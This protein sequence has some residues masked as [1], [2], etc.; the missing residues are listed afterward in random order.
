MTLRY[1]TDIVIFGGGIA[2]L[3]LLNRLQ[4]I[5]YSPLLFETNTLGG[6][7]T[8]AS[9]GIIH[10]GLKYALSGSLTQASEVIADMPSVWRQHLSG[11]GEPDLTGVPV[12]S[13]HY[14]MWSH[15]SLRSKLKA[16]LGSRSL[17]G[18]IEVVKE[19]T[20]PE[21]F[22]G[23]TSKGTL[24]QLPDFVIHTPSLLERLR[25]PVANRLLAIKEGIYQFKINTQNDKHILKIDI[26]G[27]Q[28]VIEAER[29][30]FCAGAG[31]KQLIEKTGIERTSA[32]ER[33]LHMVYLKDSDLPQ[34]Y[35]HFIGDDFSLT[36][37]LT[38]TSH[39][40]L[41]GQT[42]W[43]LGG[44]LAE[45]GVNKGRDEQILSAKHLL[46]KFLPWIDTA[47]ASWDCFSINRAE[48]NINNKYR[49]D[50]AYISVE[51]NIILGW[52]TK[53]TL[54]PSLVNKVVKI[55]TE[56]ED[57]VPAIDNSGAIAA[58]NELLGN[59]EPAKARWD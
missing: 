33:P 54:A 10:G 38:V 5:G 2:G 12:L 6:G 51:S 27:E 14:Y 47:T 30:I 22:S 23:I 45:E 1:S 32:Q 17:T 29:F 18:R 56:G 36:P 16:F 34:L 35:S 13:N 43:Y 46:D 26:N 31:N 28:I 25:E 7:Q 42:V 53:L 40:G 21:I 59:P 15:G 48:A 49:P 58:L 41:D 50:D 9:Q 24:Y 57:P 55:I 11:Q 44:N 4:N 39:T 52:P 19:E 20:Y 37:E 3:W 8:L